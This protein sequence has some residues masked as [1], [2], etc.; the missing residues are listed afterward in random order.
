[1][2]KTIRII[3]PF[4]ND[5]WGNRYVPFAP[6][7]LFDFLV[8]KIEVNVLCNFSQAV[9]LPDAFVEIE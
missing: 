8:N 7:G 5:R 3:V 1:M 6:I 4:E 9:I 2:S